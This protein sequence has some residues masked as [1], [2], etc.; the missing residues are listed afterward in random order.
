MRFKFLR[1]SVDGKHLMRF[2]S[3][4]SVFK[5]LRC[6]V[7]AT[8]V[9]SSHLYDMVLVNTLTLPRCDCAGIV[10]A[11]RLVTSCFLLYF[12]DAA[13]EWDYYYARSALTDGDQFGIEETKV[14]RSSCAGIMIKI[15]VI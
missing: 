2:Q 6:S 12:A 8:K 1:R 5:F 11:D 15:E 10:I 9:I 14:R 13:I 4:T 7:D 3:E